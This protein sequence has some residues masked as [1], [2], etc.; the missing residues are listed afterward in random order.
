MARM[1]TTTS[2]PSDLT[3]RQG[4]VL[5]FVYSRRDV[6]EVMPAECVVKIAWSDLPHTEL[7]AKTTLSALMR[8]SLVKKIGRG[9]EVTVAGR[10]L[11]I[12]ANM[13]GMWRATP[14]PEVTN[15]RRRM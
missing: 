1:K 4:K 5:R 10:N 13:K 12:S 14:P 6:G 15:Q 3:A 11:I 8:R 7:Q 2:K 9:Y